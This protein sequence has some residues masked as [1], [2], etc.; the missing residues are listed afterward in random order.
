VTLS[1][2]GG[3]GFLASLSNIVPIILYLIIIV[4]LN[5]RNVRAFFGRTGGYAVMRPPVGQPYMPP[6][7]SPYP[8]PSVQQPYYPQAS[9]QPPSWGPTT[10]PNCGALNQPGANFCDHCGTAFR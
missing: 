3:Y 5:S 9:P 6:P 4:Y 10:C 2:V 7:Q 1:L 8:Q